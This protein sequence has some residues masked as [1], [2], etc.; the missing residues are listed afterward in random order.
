MLLKEAIEDYLESRRIENYAPKTVSTLTKRLALLARFLRKKGRY[1]VV[2]VRPEDLDDYVAH[3]IRRGLKFQSRAAYLGTV[4]VF[5]DWLY[6]RGK[7]LTDPARDIRIPDEDEEPLPEP[8]L[9]EDEVSSILDR[10]P[11]RSVVDLRN[12]LHLELLYSCGL[13]MTESIELKLSD[14]SIQE[15]SVRIKGKSGK[16]RVLP[17]M[18]ATLGTLKDYLALRRSLLKGP[19]TGVLLLSHISG[20]PLS[21]ALIY[22]IIRKLRRRLKIKRRIHP[23]LFRHSIAV[24]LLQRGADIRHVQEFLGHSNIDTTKIYLRLVPGRLKEDY[25]KA[26]PMIA[27]EA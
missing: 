4:K 13:R 10:M 16:V 14:I 27:L 17:L 18:K 7:V 24:H 8:P 5:F 21:Q 6:D 20:G 22:Q 23:H 2:R 9:T 19:D 25:D 1:E 11:V 12:R 26:M 3:L 15:R